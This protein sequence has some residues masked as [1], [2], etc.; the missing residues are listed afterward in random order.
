M[1]HSRLSLTDEEGT[2]FMMELCHG[3]D[4]LVHARFLSCH[5]ENSNH[6]TTIQ[7]NL[8]K[9][10]PIEAWCCT[11]SA[12]AHAVG[13]CSHVTALLWYLALLTR[14][15]FQPTLIHFLPTN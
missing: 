13:M 12:S 4:D 11:C 5:S 3:H 7:F 9:Q 14:L 6:T 2:K 1:N 15:L 8:Q 10:Q